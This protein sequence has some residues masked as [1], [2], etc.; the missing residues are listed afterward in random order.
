MRIRR[1][2]GMCAAALA[3]SMSASYAGPCSND[4]G[5]MQAKINQKLAA[6]VTAGPPAPPSA[7]V[8][9]AQPT[10]RSLGA[11]AERMGEISHETVQAIQQAM[12]RT[13]AADSAGGQTAGNGALAAAEHI[14]DH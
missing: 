7:M 13:R 6:T 11:V 8:G 1:S 14:L 12:A 2:A 5:S 9:V 3:A 10:P 4:I